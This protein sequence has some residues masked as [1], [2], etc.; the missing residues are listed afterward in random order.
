LKPEI[1][2]HTHDQYGKPISTPDIT[3]DKNRSDQIKENH[4]KPKGEFYEYENS[5]YITDAN[6]TRFNKFYKS[7]DV[8]VNKPAAAKEFLKSELIKNLNSFVTMLIH[9]ERKK[10]PSMK[11]MKIIIHDI[12]QII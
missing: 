7:Y 10:Y 8:K 6:F 4:I 11:K 1:F 5:K 9:Q 3:P 2:M 12:H